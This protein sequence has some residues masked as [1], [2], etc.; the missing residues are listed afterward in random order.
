[1]PRPKTE[2]IERTAEGFGG[3]QEEIEKHPAFGLIQFSRIQGRPGK[4]F[5]THLNDHGSFIRMSVLRAERRH[6]LSYDRYHGTMR[7]RPVVELE[8]S[9]VQFSELLTSMNMGDG[10]PCTLRH[11]E[12][13]AIPYIPEDLET[14]QEKVAENFKREMKDLAE[15]LTKAEADVREIL[16]KKS[17]LKADREAIKRAFSKVATFLASHAPFIMD[18]FTESI[19]KSTKAG[20]AEIEAFMTNALVSAGLEGLKKKLAEAT[21]EPAL[22]SGDPEDE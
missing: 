8:L 12:G 15:T 11:Y 1:M 2:P 14:E 22:V 18:Q 7:G 17:L 19:E 6:H 9:A 13:Q 20:K 5:G 10:V 16:A 4:L 3:D 21:Q